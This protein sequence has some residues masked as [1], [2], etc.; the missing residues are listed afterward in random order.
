MSL[1]G[2]YD[3]FK[4]GYWAEEDPKNCLCYGCGWAL[5][6]VDTWHQCP[7]HFK[8]Q[9]HPE[10][11]TPDECPECEDGNNFSPLDCSLCSETIQ[12]ELASMDDNLPDNQKQVDDLP[13]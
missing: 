1:Q 13:F 6:D 5:S 8:G 12:E 10:D 3:S 9:R 2:Y 4:L 7:I 11:D